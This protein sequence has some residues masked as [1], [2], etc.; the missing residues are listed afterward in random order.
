MTTYTGKGDPTAALR[1]KLTE[2]LYVSWIWQWCSILRSQ[3]D[4]SRVGDLCYPKGTLPVGGEFV[5]AFTG[6]Y[7]SKHQVIHQKLSAMHKPLVIALERLMV[8]CILDSCLP[9]SLIDEVD[10]ITLELVLRSF[11]VCLDMGGDH[12]DLWGGGG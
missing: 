12:G 8:L 5:C 4:T 1:V 2:M 10:I 11:V 9:P 3:A 6:E 7:A